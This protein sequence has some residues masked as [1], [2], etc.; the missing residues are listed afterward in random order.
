MISLR[1]KARHVEIPKIKSDRLR[2]LK[3]RD[4]VGSGRHAKDPFVIPE[5]DIKSGKKHNK[6][7][8]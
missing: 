3:T 6:M 5:E 2:T 4:V 7:G 8:V 1:E